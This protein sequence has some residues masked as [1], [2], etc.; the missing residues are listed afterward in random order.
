MLVNTHS[1]L[2]GN[3]YADLPTKG[4]FKWN[5]FNENDKYS[6][7]ISTKNSNYCT[8]CYYIIG[9]TANISAYFTI[10]ANSKV[11][12]MALQNGVPFKAEINEDKMNIYSFQV[13]KREDLFISLSMFSGNIDFYISNNYN[14]SKVI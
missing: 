9:V 7:I 14:Q 11:K 10:H 4:I 12:V 8:F 3:F 1:D 6:L 2:S 5:T 13:N